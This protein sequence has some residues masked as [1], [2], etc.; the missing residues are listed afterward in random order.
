MLDGRSGSADRGPFFSPAEERLDAGGLLALQRR[1]L[2]DMLAEVL[3]GNVFYKTKFAGIGFDPLADPLQ[4]L[5]FTTRADLER[6][7][8]AHPPFG[9]NLT[10]PIERYRRLHQTSG[11]GGHAMRWLDTA[12]S[13]AW[14][15]KIWG[16]IFTSAGVGEEDRILFAFSF[17]PFVG[18]WGAFE[19]ASA[20]GALTLPAGGMPTAA[21]LRMC[22]ENQA[23]VVCCTPTYALH[24]AEFAQRE[25]MNLARSAVKTIVV[26]GE[27]GG[28]I[29]STR[30]RIEAA[31]GARVVDHTGMTEMGPV[32]FECRERSGGVHVVESEFIAEV[33]DPAT[34]HG[35]PDGQIGELVLSN[36]GRWGSP[37]IRYRT[38]DQVRLTR[39]AC[40]CGRSFARLEGGI[41]G[42]VDEMFI[43]RGN[44]VFPTGIEAVLRGFD[45][46]AEFRCTVV[47]G[48]ALTQVKM[49][50]EPIPA[51]ADPAGL[52]RR[53][54]EALQEALHFR[55]QVLPVAPGALPRFELKARRFIRVKSSD[56]CPNNNPAARL[57]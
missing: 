9:T 4:A 45:E 29:P 36:L 12:E 41:L 3:P 22:L 27:P 15:R 13:W 25:G 14:F 53:A 43:V 17:G 33:I 7:Q 26:A 52:A 20:V 28:S 21:R 51:C 6:D 55:A 46:V 38:G 35:V 32:S 50:V 1:K 34:G 42:R 57:S 18:F 11:T 48:S 40:A 16:I 44:N 49:E 39:G 19:G 2:A 54:G 24:M 30:A 47:E 5:P 8:L 31:W 56:T 10:Y 23:T 37:L